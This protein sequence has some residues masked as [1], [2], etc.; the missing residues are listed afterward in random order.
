MDES[1]IK[2]YLSDKLK[3]TDTSLEKLEIFEKELLSFNKEYNLISKSTESIVWHRHILDSAQLVKFIDFQN[4]KSLSD[5]GSGGGFPGMV[6]AIFNE[7]P[8]FH[9]KLFE[10][11]NIKASFLEKI[12]KM[13]ESKLKV[14][15]GSY[16]DHNIDANYILARAFKKLPEIL[17]ISREKVKN[18]HKLIVMKGK[19]AQAEVNIAL[20]VKLFKYK[21][22]Q[23]ITDTNSKIILVDEN[24]K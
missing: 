13:T 24:K 8:K 1:E 15:R 11:S 3:F 17:R 14:Y 4:N 21:L 10:K 6:M 23:S 2:D 20:K 18:A 16:I 19:N 12:A 5:L 22:V 9:V 7:N